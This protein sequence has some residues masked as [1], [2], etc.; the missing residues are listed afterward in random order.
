M[1]EFATEEGLIPL[2]FAGGSSGGGG[3]R[4]A[5]R[6]RMARPKKHPTPSQRRWRRGF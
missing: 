2:S 3:Q 6:G 5:P 1:L 4:S